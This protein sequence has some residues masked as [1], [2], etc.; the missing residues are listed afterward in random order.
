[1]PLCM[2]LE[3][4]WQYCHAWITYRSACRITLAMTDH[5]T[6]GT[7][8]HVQLGYVQQ[9]TNIRVTETTVMNVQQLKPMYDLFKQLMW[10]VC[11]LHDHA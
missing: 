5:V 1:M 8:S 3:A 6:C 10:Q 2:S 9:M 11:K 7:I 4:L